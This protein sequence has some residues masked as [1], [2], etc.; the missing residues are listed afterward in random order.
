MTY[1]LISKIG[2][3]SFGMVYKAVNNLN[4]E[5]VAIKIINL[6]ESSDDIDDIQKVIIFNYSQERN[7]NETLCTKENFF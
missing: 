7:E 5:L 6:E 4:G 3:G 2:G 1:D